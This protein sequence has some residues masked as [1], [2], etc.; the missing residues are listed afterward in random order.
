MK[1]ILSKFLISSRRLNKICTV[2]LVYLKPD[3][4]STGK[5]SVF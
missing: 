4:S 5:W 2:Y 1:F 3:Y